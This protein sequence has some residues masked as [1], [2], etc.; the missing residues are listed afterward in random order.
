MRFLKVHLP[1]GQPLQFRSLP[2]AASVLAD[3]SP[4][5]S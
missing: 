4:K 5:L 2:K 1:E 3:F